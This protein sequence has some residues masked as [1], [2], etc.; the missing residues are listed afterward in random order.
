MWGV[1]Q[2]WAGFRRAPNG[3]KKFKLNNSIGWPTQCRNS[4]GPE[5]AI[6]RTQSDRRRAIRAIHPLPFPSLYPVYTGAL[7]QSLSVFTL[8]P[9]NLIV[10]RRLEIRSPSW[11]TYSRFI[12]PVRHRA[13]IMSRTPLRD[14]ATIRK[15]PPLGSASAFS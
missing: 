7:I 11:S 13:A 1:G 14:T 8:N 10:T 2:G 6:P 4:K 12:S 5:H 3:F 15:Y 9:L